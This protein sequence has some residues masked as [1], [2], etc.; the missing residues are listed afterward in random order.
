MYCVQG[1]ETQLNLLDHAYTARMDDS[2]EDLLTF[3][4]KKEKQES[5]VNYSWPNLTNSRTMMFGSF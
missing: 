4:E 2:F 3:S 5:R 1:R